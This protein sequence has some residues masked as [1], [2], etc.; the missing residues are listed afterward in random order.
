MATLQGRFHYLYVPDEEI[1]LEK[2]QIIVPGKFYTPLKMLCLECLRCHSD[3]VLV[4]LPIV[5]WAFVI[6]FLKNKLYKLYL[7][8]VSYLQIPEKND[9]GFL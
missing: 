2:G 5:I 3:Q 8:I 6:S 9:Y 7:S 4:V 1:E